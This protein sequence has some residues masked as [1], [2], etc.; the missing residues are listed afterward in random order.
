MTNVSSLKHVIL[1]AF[2][3]LSVTGAGSVWIYDALQAGETHV[4][5][6]PFSFGPFGYDREI[7]IV[8]D[9]GATLEYTLSNAALST[10]AQALTAAAAA[11]DVAYMPMLASDVLDMVGAG[12][13][14]DYTDGTP[15]AT[16]EGTAGPGSRYT[17]ITGAKLYINGGTKAQPIWKLVTS[18]A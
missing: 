1:P 2:K 3:I 11:G 10:P 17:D 9:A 13:P 7:E 4:N 12:V 8:P 14:V 6:S 18:A 5:A 16:G 15:P